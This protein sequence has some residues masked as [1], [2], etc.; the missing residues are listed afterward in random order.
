MP[1]SDH[2]YDVCPGCNGVKR[3]VAKSCRECSRNCRRGPKY[4]PNSV[5]V[6]GDVAFVTLTD[7]SGATVAITMIDTNDL[8]KVQS[9]NLRWSAVVRETDT[10]VITSKCIAGKKS[11]IQLHRFIV[12]APD[13]TQVDHINRCPL[14][15]R[16]ANLRL[17]TGAENQQNT[18]RYRRGKTLPKGVRE[19][20]G[21]YRVT[22]GLDGRIFNFGIY[23]TAEEATAVADAKRKEMHRYA[24][25]P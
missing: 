4:E 23:D 22:I 12:D 18:R 6:V 10:R 2:R 21:K 7:R 3:K 20:A 25:G 11:T 19:C 8:A 24:A 17:V 1:R 9:M 14:D 15:N 5:V 16:R 13:G